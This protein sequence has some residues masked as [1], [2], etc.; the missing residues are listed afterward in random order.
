MTR[1]YDQEFGPD[2]IYAW[3]GCLD[4]AGRFIEAA[5]YA[6]SGPDCLDDYFFYEYLDC[7]DAELFD[8]HPEKEALEL[9]EA[10]AKSRQELFRDARNWPLPYLVTSAMYHILSTKAERIHKIN[11]F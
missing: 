6:E 9:V 8:E 4:V 2:G 11:G 7:L 1:N 3:P 5:P 10:A